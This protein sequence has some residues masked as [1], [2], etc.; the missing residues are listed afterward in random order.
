MAEP[1]LCHVGLCLNAFF[2][3][4]FPSDKIILVNGGPDFVVLVQALELCVIYSYT[5]L[6]SLVYQLSTPLWASM[7]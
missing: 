5:F 4:R 2:V 6:V 7:L 1:Q 3:E